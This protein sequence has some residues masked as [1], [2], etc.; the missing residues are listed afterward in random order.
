MRYQNFYLLLC[1]I[2]LSVLPGCKSGNGPLAPGEFKIAACF[3]INVWPGGI[4]GSDIRFDASCSSDNYFDIVEFTWVWGD[5][6]GAESL[7]SPEIYHVFEEIGVYEIALTIKDEAGNVASTSRDLEIREDVPGANFTFN[8]PDGFYPGKEILFDASHSVDAHFEIVEYRWDWDD[9]SDVR[10]TVNPEI[11][12]IF[13]SV[14]IY[15]VELTVRNSFDKEGSR[16]QDVEIVEIP[17]TVP[18]ACFTYDAQNGWEPGSEIYFDASCSRDID[19]DNVTY[20]WDWGDGSPSDESNS[21]RASHVFDTSD[22]TVVLTV[23]DDDGNEASTE[24][25][26]LTFGNP[27]G[28]SPVQVYS[29]SAGVF[30]S[31]WT[32]AFNEDYMFIAK[33]GSVWVYEINYPYYCTEFSHE[34]SYEYADPLQMAC[35]DDLLIVNRIIEDS[36]MGFIE[37]W[38]VTDGQPMQAYTWHLTADYIDISGNLAFLL[39]GTNLQIWDVTDPLTPVYYS[40]VSQEELEF[41]IE[42][43]RLFSNAYGTTVKVYDIT[44]PVEPVLEGTLPIIPAA[45]KD[46]SAYWVSD[47]R[48]YSVDITDPSSYQVL[49]S[50]ELW[51]DISNSNIELCGDRLLVGSNNGLGFAVVAVT[52]P[53]RPEIVGSV[54][55][56]FRPDQV[57]SNQ[58]PFIYQIWSESVQ[59]FD[60]PV[61]YTIYYNRVSVLDIS[62]PVGPHFTSSRM[63]GT[64]M[65]TL[66]ALDVEISWNHAFITSDPG[67]LII[68]DLEDPFEPVLIGRS[69]DFTGAR[70]VVVNYDRV[71]IGCEDP[72]LLV[73]DVSDRSTIEVTG[74]AICPG[75]N[76]F[77]IDGNI[78]YLVGDYE[79]TVKICDLADRDNPE[80]IA[81]YGAA[82]HGTT[83]EY[84]NGFL[85]IGT[86]SADLIYVDVREPE[87]PVITYPVINKQWSNGIQDSSLTNG[88]LCLYDDFL[89][90]DGAYFQSGPRFR[91]YDISSPP[92]IFQIG[93]SKIGSFSSTSRLDFQ[94]TGDYAFTPAFSTLRILRIINP[95]SISRINLVPVNP[96]T[97]NAVGVEC[98]L[99]LT[100]GYTSDQGAI[101]YS[102]TKLW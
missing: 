41:F 48:L 95:N 42:G 9:G 64:G 89:M 78:A 97:L 75:T 35:A 52:D 13:N 26:E 76:D 66:N 45:V 100:A 5:G 73:V 40:S 87:E 7:D 90:Y 57:I 67:G 56:D 27:G 51:D 85:C 12:H 43:S 61:Y 10:S 2:L 49:G 34:T 23:R 98:N 19:G 63:V 29:E 81:D 68:V 11:T 72:G 84:L 30:P 86:E 6:S 50:C 18:S 93:Y 46:D 92:A 16:S 20:Q 58:P 71:Y 44:N 101:C 83:V 82:V 39:V 94:V 36:S 1:L 91:I 24:P 80:L 22:A 4:P 96:Q 37:L 88:A 65:E 77:V 47:S 14:G 54:N 59:F 55:Q 79:T 33:P 32:F 25:L 69:V 31:Q 53:L 15:E 74:S 99:A 3:N 38:D 70:K 62:E 21:P 28:F 60:Y 102:V 8:A 17:D